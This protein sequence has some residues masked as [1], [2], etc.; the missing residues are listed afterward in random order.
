[1]NTIHVLANDLINQIA[2]GE[3]I[4]NPSSVVKELVENSLDASA[5]HITVRIKAGGLFQI[6]VEDDGK[7]MT[8]EEAL[9]CIERHATS[10]IYSLEDLQEVMTMGFRGEAL[11]SIAAISKMTI[12]TSQGEKAY[13]IIVESGKI[14]SSHLSTR[15]K[16]TTITVNSLFY[17]VPVRKK[18]QKSIPSMITEI[19]RLLTKLSLSRPQK[20]FSLYSDDQLLLQTQSYEHLDYKTALKETIQDVLGEDFF[21]QL[22]EISYEDAL[23]KIEGFLGKESLAKKTRTSQYLFINTR[24]VYSHNISQM[25]KEGYNTRLASDCFPSF[26]INI[27]LPYSYVDVNVHPQKREVRIKNEIVIKEKIL[28][29]I[30]QAFTIKTTS[31]LALDSQQFFTA[32]SYPAEYVVNA[33]EMQKNKNFASFQDRM[34]FSYPDQVQQNFI[35]FSL[36]PYVFVNGNFLSQSIHETMIV[37]LRR[38]S[39]RLLMDAHLKNETIQSQ[40]LALPVLIDLNLEEMALFLQ[41]SSS[42]TK[43]ALDCRQVSQNTIA[44]DACPVFLSPKEAKDFIR[45]VLENE[46]NVS[47]VVQ[48]QKEKKLVKSLQTFCLKRQEAYS[49]DEKKELLLKWKN[50]SNPHLDPSGFSIYKILKKEDFDNLFKK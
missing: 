45:L 7:G 14:L 29:A 35:V 4:E 25:I 5:Q 32:T 43:W 20:G 12:E 34:L 13:Q 10:K 16:G 9:L 37:D 26:V 50:S 30:S 1:M 11:S 49:E 18:F 40:T 42:F 46:E 48:E 41:N 44:L 17:T 22:I 39:F 3:V 28:K 23:I 8:Q 15:T 21:S 27:S 6:I 36:D 24:S 31:H 38:V 19:V 47:L 33:D 2:A